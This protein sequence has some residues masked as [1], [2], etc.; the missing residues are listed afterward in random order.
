LGLGFC[1][2]DVIRG[3][4]FFPYGQVYLALGVNEPSFWLTF[5]GN[6][7]MI[8]KKVARAGLKG[9]TITV[10][11]ISPYFYATKRI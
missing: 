9:F 6:Q 7:A 10:F 2:N 3:T 5:F 4:C 1:V 8:A 11:F